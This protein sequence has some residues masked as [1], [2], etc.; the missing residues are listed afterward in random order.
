MK[1]IDRMTPWEYTLRTKAYLL[2]QNEA[3]RRVYTTAFANR[4]FKAEKKGRFVIKD[5]KSIYDYEKNEQ[6]I[7]ADFKQKGIQKQE[8]TEDLYEMRQR[9]IRAKEIVSKKN[10]KGGK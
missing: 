10:Q 9:L 7:L 1:E 6:T 4:L 2:N 8:D 3:E 5:V